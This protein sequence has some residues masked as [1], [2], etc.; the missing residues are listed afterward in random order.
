MPMSVVKARL[1][2]A[3]NPG[4]RVLELDWQMCQMDPPRQAERKRR[5]RSPRSWVKAGVLSHG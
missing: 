1:S 3:V 5:L 2:G 4:A